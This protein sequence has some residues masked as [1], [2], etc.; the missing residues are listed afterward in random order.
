[1]VL[2]ERASP[3]PEVEAVR[4]NLKIRPLEERDLDVADQIM[5]IAFGTYLR[6]PNPIEALGDADWVHTRYYADP[7]A[8]FCAELDSEVVGSNF[9][10]RWG[11]FGFFGPLS[12]RVDLWDRG[13]ATR[14]M[15]PPTWAR[16]TSHSGP[17]S[18]LTAP[19]MVRMA[20]SDRLT[21]SCVFQ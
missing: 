19:A 5:R 10:T 2:S 20:A 1:M 4:R 9:A 16:K 12:V 17:G 21:K 18:F 13:I 15:A 14:L 3:S 8:A 6:A 7:A 11:S